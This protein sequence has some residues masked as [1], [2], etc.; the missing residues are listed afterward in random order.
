[1]IAS[2]RQCIDLINWLTAWI[3]GR[4]TRAF[5]HVSPWSSRVDYWI[6]TL[7]WEPNGRIRNTRVIF[8]RIK[9]IKRMRFATMHGECYS[10]IKTKIF[11]SINFYVTKDTH[12]P[13]NFPKNY[14]QNCTFTK[15]F[16]SHFFIPY[17]YKGEIYTKCNHLI[18]YRIF[19]F[20]CK[21]Y[22]Y[23]NIIIYY[24]SVEKFNKNENWKLLII[25][26]EKWNV[27]TNYDYQ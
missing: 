12:I 27:R 17:L 10:K 5:H 18:T 6:D 19:Q 26:I 11:E 16:S 15:I 22:G 9:C 1:M 13:E 4:W 7:R 23:F 14:S 2:D 3:A 25:N 8:S 21:K 20:E 24:F